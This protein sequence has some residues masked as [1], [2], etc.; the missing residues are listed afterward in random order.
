MLW[1]AQALGRSGIDQPLRL[2]V[3]SNSMQDV[4]GEPV[5]LPQRATLLGPAKVMPVEY[6]FVRVTSVD[7]ALAANGDYTGVA[8]QLIGEAQRAD[9][10]LVVAYRQRHRWLQTFERAPLDSPLP[11][12]LPLRDG[13]SIGSPVGLGGVGQRVL[14]VDVDLDVTLLHHVEQVVGGL[15]QVLAL[16]HV[17]HQRGPRH[18]QRALGGEQAGIEGGDRA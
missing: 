15:H 2:L 13:A 6:P 17:G 4:A 11:A 8:H 10:A 12:D 1:L 9:S 16:G 5:L 14:V 18:V 3:V 7:V